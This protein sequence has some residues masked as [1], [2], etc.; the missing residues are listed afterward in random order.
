[1]RIIERDISEISTYGKHKSSAGEL[2]HFCVNLDQV[3]FARCISRMIL[4]DSETEK[5]VD[6]S[7][8]VKRRFKYSVY[9]K[10]FVRLM[11]NMAAPMVYF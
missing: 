2:F 9:T 8:L 6:R 7:V 10:P 3:H 11:L 4:V 1:M 5:G